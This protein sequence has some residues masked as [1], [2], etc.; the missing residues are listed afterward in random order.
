[1]RTASIAAPTSTVDMGL[2]SGEGIP[3][4][5]R[6]P[7]EVTHLAGLSLAPEGVRAAHP[8]FDVTPHELVTAIITEK[9]VVDPPFAEGLRRLLVEPRKSDVPR[10]SGM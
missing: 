10:S 9:G 4:E 7:D 8:A 2:A 5:Q 3:I 1:M 6:D